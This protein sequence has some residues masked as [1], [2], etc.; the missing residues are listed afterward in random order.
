MRPA[1]TLVA[2]AA[3]GLGVVAAVHAAPTILAITPL[4][5]TLA[6]RLFGRGRAG[7]VA[8]TFDDGPDPATTPLFLVELDRL[9]W[10]ATFFM[11]GCMARRNPGLAREVAAAGH[12]IAV[13]GDIHRS[14]LLRRAQEVRDD[15]ERAGDSIAEA[16]R[17]SPAFYRPPFGALSRSALRAAGDARLSTVLWT[18]CGRDWTSHATA[19]SVA[20]HATRRSLSGATLLLHDSDCT[21][22]AGAWRS[23]LGALPLLADHAMARGL[24]FGCLGDHGSDPNPNWPR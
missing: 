7:H 24:E 19:A 16:T 11:L 1:T 6:P 17:C 8:L 15:L 3:G 9:G 13:H 22:A 12:E 23:T 4:G 21:S 2:A 18:A 5:E 20:A 10:H 14:T